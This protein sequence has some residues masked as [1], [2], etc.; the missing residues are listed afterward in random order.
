MNKKTITT[1][2]AVIGALATVAALLYIFRDKLAALCKKCSGR[3]C[4]LP[5]T[6]DEAAE[7]F[8]EAVEDAADTVKETVETT[9]EEAKDAAADAAEKAAAIAEE[10]KDYADVELP[11]ETIE[12]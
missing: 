9:V 5:E 11:V 6:P 7:D 10:F 8:A 2:L 3:D 1:I 4:E 12:E